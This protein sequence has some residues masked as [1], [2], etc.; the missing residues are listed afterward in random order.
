MKQNTEY[1]DMLRKNGLREAAL[2]LETSLVKFPLTK[3]HRMATP[4]W[5]LVMERNRGKERVFLT[6]ESELGYPLL[7]RFVW[8]LENGWFPAGGLNTSFKEFRLFLG[9]AVDGKAVARFDADIDGV[10]AIVNGLLLAGVNASLCAIGEPAEREVVVKRPKK[11]KTDTS[12]P[13]PVLNLDNP[14]RV[15]QMVEKPKSKFV[16]EP[17]ELKIG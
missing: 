5:M 1:A 12:V 15:V 8:A 6:D 2:K 10:C 3:G 4:G 13:A 11:A 9:L 16:E 7:A 17:D 14:V